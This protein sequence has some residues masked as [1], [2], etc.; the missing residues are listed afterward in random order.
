[1]DELREKADR[2]QAELAVVEREWNEWVIARSRVGEVLAP[3]D[4]DGTDA[5]KDLADAGQPPTAASFSGA[6]KPKSVVPMCRA[7][8]AWPALSADH[9]LFERV[10]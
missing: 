10:A 7:G 1:M 8:P 4:D 3:G 9:L 6:A 2:I 5:G